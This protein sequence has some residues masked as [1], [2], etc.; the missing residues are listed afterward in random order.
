MEG[1]SEFMKQFKELEHSGN[2]RS[3]AEHSLKNEGVESK[4]DHVKFEQGLN[5]YAE[6]LEETYKD[7]TK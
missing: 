6:W 2:F 4:R 1:T 5:A 3:I 7:N